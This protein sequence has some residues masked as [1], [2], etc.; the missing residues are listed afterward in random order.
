MLQLSKAGSQKAHRALATA[1][2][3]RL[4]RKKP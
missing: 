3:K 1:I 2:A 4:R